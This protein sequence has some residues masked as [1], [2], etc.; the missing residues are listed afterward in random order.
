MGRNAE[1]VAD[2]EMLVSKADEISGASALKTL[3]RWAEEEGRLKDAVV[4][5]NRA[6][7]L[8]SGR[9]EPD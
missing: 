4:F 6:R 9:T 3:G 8:N 1:A 5:L 7:S 2:L